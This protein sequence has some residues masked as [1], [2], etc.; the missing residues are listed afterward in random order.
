MTN[1]INPK[2]PDEILDIVGND[3]FEANDV[4]MSDSKVL[5]YPN[6]VLKIQ[7]ESEETLNEKNIVTWLAGQLPV[8]MILVYSV[9]DE[10]AYTLMTK[11][12]GKML[13][14]AEYLNNPSLVIK[15]VAGCLKAL[16]KVDVAHCPFKTSRLEERL[17]QAR[18]NVLENRN[19]IDNV[20]PTTFSVDG[21]KNSLELLNWLENN[22]PIEDI[23]LSHGD[24]CLPNIIVQNNKISGYIDLGK[25]GPADRWQ[26]I[27][28]AIRS[29]GD[30]FAGKYNGGIKYFDFEPQMLLDELGLEMDYEKYKYYLLLDELF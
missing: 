25:M 26:D 17:K 10:I 29:L 19:D 16:W 2:I 14:D 13:C 24:F 4:G 7:A 23:V 15:M 21:F 8:P 9:K 20:M 28:I 12:N 30:N 6:H 5:I 1:M 22:R 11:I 18:K 3:V 27:A